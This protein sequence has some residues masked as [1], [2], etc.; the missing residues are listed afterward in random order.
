MCRNAK[1]EAAMRFAIAVFL[2]TTVAGQAQMMQTTVNAQDGGTRE[3]LESIVVPMITNAPFYSTLATEWVRPLTDGGTVTFANQRHIARDSSGRLYEERWYLV[4]KN[5]NV[6]ST[7]N[8]IQIADPAKH[9]LYTCNTARRV[10]ELTAYYESVSAPRKESTPTGPLPNDTGQ[11]T[12]ENLG[13]QVIAGLETEG[14][15]A[16]TTLNPGVVG[17]DRPMT[18]TRE[19]WYSPQLGFNLLSKR[20]D[21]RIGTQTFTIIELSLSEPEPQIFDPPDGFKIEDHRTKSESGPLQ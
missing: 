11:Q 14:T 7:M 8:Y 4:P 12:A 1:L 3:V 2:L 18:I 5:G 21:P 9:T 6:K 20:N 15:R 10:C 16:S 17:N 19:F 13:K